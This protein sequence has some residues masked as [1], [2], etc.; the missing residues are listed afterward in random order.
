MALSWQLPHF[1]HKSVNLSERLRE[2]EGEV[3]EGLRREEALEALEGAPSL[4][5]FD[6]RKSEDAV[7]GSVHVADPFRDSD[8]ERRKDVNQVKV[9][10]AVARVHVSSERSAAGG[11]NTRG[12]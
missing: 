1:H 9:I 3:G 2:D 6:G 12:R 10:T 7:N 4:D 11:G 8:R 5:G